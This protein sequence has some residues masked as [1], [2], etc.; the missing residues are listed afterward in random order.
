MLI[1]RYV[2]VVVIICQLDENQNLYS[3]ECWYLGTASAADG[4]QKNIKLQKQYAE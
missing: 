3:I 1:Y 2:L 4:W